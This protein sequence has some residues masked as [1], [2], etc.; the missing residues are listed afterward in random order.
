[1]S[2]TIT[3]MKAAMIPSLVSL[4]Q[5]MKKS[6]LPSWSYILKERPQVLMG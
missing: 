5:Q 1:M 3:L 2:E 6:E 4:S